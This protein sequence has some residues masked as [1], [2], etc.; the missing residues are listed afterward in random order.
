MD[1]RNLYFPNCEV[2]LAKTDSFNPKVKCENGIVWVEAQYPS[3]QI[4][5]V[6][7]SSLKQKTEAN[8]KQFQQIIWALQDTINSLGLSKAEVS[9][10]LRCYGVIGK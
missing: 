5:W 1:A 9:R 4:V 2:N 7:L 3:G 10:R 6:R 8:E